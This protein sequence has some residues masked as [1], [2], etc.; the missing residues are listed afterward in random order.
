MGLYSLLFP[1]SPPLTE[2]NLPNQ[3]GKV[4]LVTGGS[5]GIGYELCSILYR[6]GGRVYLAG[7][8]ESAANEAIRQIKTLSTST[9]G[10]LIF[11]YIALDDLASVQSGAARFLEQESRLDVLFNN[12][13]VSLPPAGSV[14]PQGH[15]LMLA[16]NALGPYLLTK[17]LSPAL[18]KTAKDTAPA[19]V[20]LVFTTSI[21]AEYS[22]PKD[23]LDVSNLTKPSASQQTNYAAS[24]VA[25]YFF[26]SYFASQ[27]GPHGILSVAQNPGNM[28]TSLLRH[29]PWIFTILVRP[30][31]YHAK[32]G[33]YTELWSGSVHSNLRP[34]LV[35]ATKTKEEGGTG[36]AQEVVSFCD[37]A[38]ANFQRV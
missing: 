32:F 24:K 33:A 29:M 28:K 6:A 35:A 1:P 37:R 12:A 16:T 34:D 13:G 3:A 2:A 22:T 5:S 14:S 21:V 38:T 23:G 31:L 4:F 10:E 11:L 17:L 7:R 19:S 25:N 18:I 20:R 27:L 36:I 30:L 26:A 15:E 9:P 8:S